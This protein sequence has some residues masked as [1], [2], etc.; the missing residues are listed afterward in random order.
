[1]CVWFVPFV[2]RNSGQIERE[3]GLCVCVETLFWSI[4]CS[5]D[6]LFLV[7]PVSTRL[8]AGNVFFSNFFVKK[9]KPAISNIQWS[10]FLHRD[11]LD[12]TE[13]DSSLPHLPAHAW[14]RCPADASATPTA[15]TASRSSVDLDDDDVPFRISLMFFIYLLAC[16]QTTHTHIIHLICKTVLSK[17]KYRRRLRLV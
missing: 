1:V 16:P 3:R 15:S 4:T 10:P 14:L 8:S 13:P 7:T 5:L 17:N 6:S 12:I 11:L 9:E 2:V